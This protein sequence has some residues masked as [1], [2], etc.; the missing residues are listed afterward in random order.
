M[1]G[2]RQ[3]SQAVSE[4]NSKNWVSIQ[5]IIVNTLE[6]NFTEH[7]DLA[8]VYLVRH[9]ETSWSLSGQHTAR[10]DLPLTE[11]GGLKSWRLG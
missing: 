1:S 5:E 7:P 3:P 8:R 9:G 2:P 6:S 10:T 11:H 4:K